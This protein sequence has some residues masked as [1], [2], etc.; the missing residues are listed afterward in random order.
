MEVFIGLHN[1][2]VCI[3]DGEVIFQHEAH[4][5]RVSGGD[6]LFECPQA[7]IV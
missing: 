2:V 6:P 1:P 3:H 7:W 5:N 4:C